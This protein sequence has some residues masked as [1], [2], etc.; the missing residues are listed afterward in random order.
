MLKRSQDEKRRIRGRMKRNEGEEEGR[1]S[2]E[3]E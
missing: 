1:G 3:G 2:K